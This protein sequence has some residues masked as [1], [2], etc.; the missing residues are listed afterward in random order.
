MA[1]DQ[2]VA[3]VDGKKIGVIQV[4]GQFLVPV[5]ETEDHRFFFGE[6]FRTLP[7]AVVGLERLVEHAH[8]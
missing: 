5:V 1:D 2:Y 6:E 7:D 4:S 8:A 3:T